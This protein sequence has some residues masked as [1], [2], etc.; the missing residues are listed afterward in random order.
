MSIL[1]FFHP[2]VKFQQTEPD[3]ERLFGWCP[4]RKIHLQHAT[5]RQL[6]ETKLISDQHWSEYYKFTFVRNPWDRAYSDYIWMH[7]YSGLNDTFKNYLNKK[8]KFR[9][10]LTDDSS[11]YFV[12][13]H[14]RPQTDYFDF[15]GN[16]KPDFIGRF[17]NFAADIAKV[18]ETLSIEQP[19]NVYEN[20]TVRKKEYSHFYTNTNKTLV[21]KRFRRDIQ[22]LNYHF[23]D[24]RSGLL[25]LKR[26]L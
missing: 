8:G 25:A 6:L 21:S 1:S 18:L 17:E 5:A 3:Y 12:G 7:K 16:L 10:I 20:S 23:E 24:K 2:G 22:A 15:E 4:K 14:L 9:T 13:D 11:Q 26:L 19:F